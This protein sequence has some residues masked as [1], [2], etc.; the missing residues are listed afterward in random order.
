[1]DKT[2]TA[3][4]QMD[5]KVK[6]PWYGY[7]SLILAILFFSGIF[8]D[9][10]GPLRAL[11]FTNLSGSIG[12]LGVIEETAGTLASSFRG[13]GGSGA[14]DGWMFGLTLVPTVM[15]ALGVVKV[16]E[17]L[18]GLD[19]AQVLLT[20]LLKPVLGIPGIAGLTLIAALQSADAG[21]SMLNG[22][23]ETGKLDEKQ[24]TIFAAFQFSAGGTITNYL[25]TC[26]A[27]FAY[28]EVSIML[29][30]VMILVFKVIGANLMRL[31]LK[32]VE[33]KGN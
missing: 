20:P 8:N 12:K 32:R 17:H 33:R 29:P 25:A 4:T 10:E 16:V 7:V 21:A 15:F 9:V 6:V 14:K 3:S 26:A 13:V 22:L 19:A 2:K 18:H 28:L 5:E 27:L 1:M 30:L 23:S 31:Y 11:D 24:K